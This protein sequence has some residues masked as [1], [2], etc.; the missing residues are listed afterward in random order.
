MQPGDSLAII[1]AIYGLPVSVLIRAN[2]LINPDYLEVGQSITIPALDPSMQPSPF[3]I[4]P[5]SELI[6]SPYSA[7]L[8][9]G[10]FISR[11]GGYLSAY[12]EEVDGIPTSGTDILQRIAQEYSVNPRLLLA[13]LEY[14]SGWVTHM[15]PD[16]VTIDY[17]MR[18]QDPARKGLYYQLAWV[19]NQ[20]NRGY[21]MWKANAISYLVLTDG[22]LVTMPSEINAGTAG[23]QAAF[24]TLLDSS[25]WSLAVSVEGFYATFIDFFGIPFDY[26]IEPVIPEGL[27]QPGFILPFEEGVSWSFT[28]GPHASWGDGSTWGALDFSPP[29]DLYGCFSSN[30]WVTAVA[31]G[32]IARS[33]NGEV[34]LDL[35]GDGLEQ[36]GWVVLY[37]HIES[38]DRIPVGT[39][40]KAGDRIGHASCEGGISTGTHFH[41]ARRYNGEW[42][43]A[44]SDMPFDFEGWI[45]ASDG[46][47]YNGTLTRD[48]ITVTAYEGRFAENQISR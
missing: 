32:I 2:S 37:M 23:I 6:Y 1:A 19:A 18:L 28:G 41:I 47:E 7:I 21:Y 5:D 4:L 46:T 33:A 3:K 43:P 13:F 27:Q 42:I 26:S 10:R 38:R 45:A 14:Q 16:P 34:I 36:T 40:V 25:A 22:N 15:N 24:S 30:A 48:G 8:D 29:G 11:H 17:P 39:Q 35:D 9:V 12:T 31:D 20:V 44:A